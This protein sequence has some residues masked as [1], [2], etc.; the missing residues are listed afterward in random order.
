[1]SQP[2]DREERFRRLYR[3]HGRA[4]LAYAVRRTADPQDAADVLADT[5]LVAWRRLEELPSGDH[6]LLWLYGV[7]RRTLANQRRAEQR[8]GRLAERL[9]HELPAALAAAS[10]PGAPP[11][12]AVLHALRELTADEREILLLAGWEQLMP[13]QIAGALGISGLAAR[14][15]LHRARRRLAAGLAAQQA[16]PTEA[17]SPLHMEEAR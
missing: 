5:F 12:R 6:A 13:S 1:M 15:R 9:R 11:D 16:Q 7:A 3:A 17:A 2:P 8:R 10:P 14:S 4:V